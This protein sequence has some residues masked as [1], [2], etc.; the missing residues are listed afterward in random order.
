MEISFPFQEVAFLPI[1]GS[2]EK[3]FSL[4]T[5]THR[6]SIKNRS[7]CLG[8]SLRFEISIGETLPTVPGISL[9]LLPLPNF[10]FPSRK[11][12]PHFSGW[13]KQLLEVCPPHVLLSLCFFFG[14]VCYGKKRKNFGLFLPLFHIEGIL[15]C[16]DVILFYFYFFNILIGFWI[17]YFDLSRKFPVRVVLK[18]EKRR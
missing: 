9:S 15:I 13:E 18:G 10:P 5:Y 17:W 3:K 11:L 12:L 8:K 7:Y 14:G 6:Y 16:G 1:S 4:F 2:R